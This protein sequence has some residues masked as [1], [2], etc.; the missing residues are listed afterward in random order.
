MLIRYW[1]WAINGG[2]GQAALYYSPHR[3][4]QCIRARL[5]GGLLAV[6]HSVNRYRRVKG[7]INELSVCLLLFTASGLAVR[8]LNNTHFNHKAV[9]VM[10]NVRCNAGRRVL[11]S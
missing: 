10:H 4:Y 2:I 1:L 7:P 9:S 6:P 11:C 8:A 3:Q 5:S